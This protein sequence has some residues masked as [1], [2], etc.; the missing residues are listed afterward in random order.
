MIY[1]KSN[2]TS[3]TTTPSDRT[4]PRL[5]PG[6][7]VL[8]R[9]TRLARLYPTDSRIC[10]LRPSAPSPHPAAEGLYDPDTQQMDKKA[11]NTP[12]NLWSRRSKYACMSSIPQDAILTAHATNS[13]S[14]L[15]LSVNKSDNADERSAPSAKRFNSLT[16]HGKSNPFTAPAVASPTSSGAS[17]AFGL[18]SGAFAS[19]GSASRT[20]KTPGSAF[21]FSK[22]G[23]DKKQEGSDKESSDKDVAQRPAVRKTASATRPPTTNSSDAAP[24]TANGPQS[25]PLRYGWVM[26]YRPPSSKNTDYEKSIRPVA[27]I[28][29]AQGFWQVYVHLKR[30]SALPAVSDYHFFKEGIRPVWEDDENKKGGKWMMRLKKGVA[31]R[32]W[33]DLLL[34]F[35]GDQFLEAS[36]EVCGLVVSVRQG[37]DVFSLWTKNDGGR[38]VKI[39]E[40]VKRV[41]KLPADTAIEWKSHNESISQK[42]ESDKV[43][44]TN[45]EKRRNTLNAQGGKTEQLPIRQ[46]V[47]A[48]ETS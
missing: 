47:E 40:T 44:A 41:L 6:S 1:H 20:P 13:N 35:I 31:D 48:E 43:R 25:W 24:N 9:I 28:H 2:T 17:S 16:G 34:A 15:S 27:K 3:I 30:P 8:T 38:N 32:Y 7:A 4:N 23:G 33:E 11:E 14:K 26:Y 39:R 46:P 22:G 12:A 5:S 21:D 37:E 45:S 29:T 10:L 18:G 42:V 36:E 19:F